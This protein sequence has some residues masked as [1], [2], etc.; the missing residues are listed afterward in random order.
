MVNELY[1]LFGVTHSDV[2]VSSMTSHATSILVA[3]TIGVCV[4][5]ALIVAGLLHLRR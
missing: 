1:E 2:C 3:G 5:I 4:I